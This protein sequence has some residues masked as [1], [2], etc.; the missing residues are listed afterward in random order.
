[1][2]DSAS[3]A[4][5]KD[6]ILRLLLTEGPLTATNLG[7]V[8]G[9]STPGVRRHLDNLLAEGLIGPATKPRRGAKGPG[10]PARAFELTDAGR[11][12]FGHG[13]DSL[14]ALALAELEALGGREAVRRFAK[15][16]A[17]NIVAGIAP[18]DANRSVVDATRELVD[19]FSESGHA[20]EVSRVNHSLEI[21]RHHCPVSNIAADYPEL[22]S[23]EHEAIA[24]VLG[25]PVQPLALISAG[26]GVCTTAVALPRD[27][28]DN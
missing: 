20:A 18:P 8:L 6:R 11:A 13:Y 28:L 1:M 4:P 19:A 10:R 16:R 14:A 15:R 25:R 7:R 27:R 26:H 5:T 21:C 22:C 12:Q 3:T 9:M 17:D 2:A 23:A 24:G